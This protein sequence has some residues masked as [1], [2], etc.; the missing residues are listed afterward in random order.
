[1]RVRHILFLLFISVIVIGMFSM[2][3]KKNYVVNVIRNVRPMSFNDTIQWVYD[4][5]DALGPGIET[6][7]SNR[8]TPYRF[9]G[10]NSQLNELYFTFAKKGD[11]LTKAK[12]SDFFFIRRKDTLVRFD[13]GE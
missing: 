11:F 5:K 9:S 6:K 3:F 4:Y 7:F 12:D 10:Y 8:D 2:I 13:L 1:M